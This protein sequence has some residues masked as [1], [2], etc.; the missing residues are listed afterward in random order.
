MNAGGVSVFALQLARLFG[1]RVIATTSSEE[2]AERLRELGAESV[3]NYVENPNW[4]ALVRDLT[5]GRGVDL[6]QRNG[7]FPAGLRCTDRH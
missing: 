2:K 7:D 6:T 4:G 1:C 5:D 3:V